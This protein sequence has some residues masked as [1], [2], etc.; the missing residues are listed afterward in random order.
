MKCAQGRGGS[1]TGLQPAPASGT[2]WPSRSPGH[3]PVPAGSFPWQTWQCCG[4][5]SISPHCRWHRPHSHCTQ[6][7]AGC[8]GEPRCLHRTGSSIPTAHRCPAW[9]SLDLCSQPNRAERSGKAKHQGLLSQSVGCCRRARCQ[10][11]PY[12]GG[13]DSVAGAGLR[14][15][16]AASRDSRAQL[17][18]AAVTAAGPAATPASAD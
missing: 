18:L 8:N 3:G 7:P 12:A 5:E 15:R 11:H 4:R 9:A 1:I 13:G 14:P 16:R 17:G 2:P 6:S 10:R